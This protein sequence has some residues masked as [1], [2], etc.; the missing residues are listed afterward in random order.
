MTE[1]IHLLVG[2]YVLD[3]LDADEVALFEAHLE[4][5]EDCRREVA[6]LAETTASLAY[7]ESGADV[8][9][10]RDSVM[11][12]IGTVPQLPPANVVG[13]KRRDLTRRIS[14]LATAAAVLVAVVLA[15]NLWSRDQTITAM[16]KHSDEVMSLVTAQ[17]AKIM[18]LGIPGADSTVV[19]S[20]ERDEAMVMG[21]EVPTPDKG[22]VYQVWAYDDAGN[23]SP[24]GTWAPDA[25]G[26]A[27]APIDADL[28][29]TRMLSVTVE[30][31]GGSAAPTSPPLTMVELA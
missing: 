2:P 8:S 11:S 9:D 24:S 26:H 17:D 6:E 16:N 23:P 18:P 10:L 19:I 14:W 12:A 15:G 7:A 20:M 29:D 1:S 25:T 27:A 3:A 31:A 4:E 28:H 13:L 5:C 30:P 21:S 22:M